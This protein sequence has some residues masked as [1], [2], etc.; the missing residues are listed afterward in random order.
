LKTKK[1]LSELIRC[2]CRHEAGHYVAA[3]ALG[4]K[5][6]GC[7]VQI[8][9]YF[10]A[11]SGGCTIL[12]PTSINS[13]NDAINYLERRSQVL[14]SGA[15]GESLNNGKVQAEEALRIIQGQEGACDHAKARELINLLRNLKYPDLVADDVAQ[16][17]LNGLDATIWR[18]ATA[19]VE[20]EA[21]KIAKLESVFG[22][23]VKGVGLKHDF[24]ETQ[25]AAA[26]L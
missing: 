19:L 5:T 18:E 26:I 3:R 15:L 14:Y 13:I 24:T 16:K 12:L 7:H 10:G 2:V 1:T 8:I 22:S 4:F 20:K 25:C 21:V 23:V 17:Q 6:N 9:N 11:Y